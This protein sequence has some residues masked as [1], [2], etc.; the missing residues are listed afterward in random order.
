M[1][2]LL[3]SKKFW[4]E[5]ISVNG[6]KLMMHIAVSD[7]T[8]EQIRASVKE[9]FPDAQV[10]G[11]VNS[12]LIRRVLKNGNTSR[13]YLLQMKGLH[14]LLQ[15]SMELPKDMTKECP[16]DLWPGSFPLPSGATDLQLMNFTKRDSQ[17]ATCSVK[18][19][20]IPYLL[21]Q[22]SIKLKAQGWTPSTAEHTDIFEGTGEVFVKDK[23]TKLL[24]IGAVHDTQGNV[25]V[26]YYQRELSEGN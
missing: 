17:F 4:T 20:Q 9:A 26:S 7:Y 16:K 10:A 18:S 14:S 22:L 6:Q 19:S 24:L 21:E 3:G 25:Q 13:I 2:S 8:L 1:A 5:P 11:N 12:L 23:P 15:F